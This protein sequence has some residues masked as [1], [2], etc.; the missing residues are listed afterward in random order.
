MSAGIRWTEDQLVEYRRRQAVYGDVRKATGSVIVTGPKSEVE[1]PV[2]EVAAER[3]G[4]L[5]VEFSDGRRFRSKA[6][7]RYALMLQEQWCAG[8]IEGWLYEPIR[9]ELADRV[10]YTPDFFVFPRGEKPQVVEVKG[11]YIRE[12]GRIKMRVAARE[13]AW[14][15]DWYLAQEIK[16]A[17]TVTKL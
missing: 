6:E 8:E 12:P 3:I 7:E 5:R 2:Q 4:S 9:L 13:F 17:W 15:G 1:I 14:L 16:G 10:R 11:P